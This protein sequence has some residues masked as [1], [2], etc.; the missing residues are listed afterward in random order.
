MIHALYRSSDGQLH[1]DLKPDDFKAAL[2][3]ERSL[4]WVDLQGEPPEA[5]EPILRDVFGFH[6]LAVDDALRESHVP[7]LDDWGEYLYLVLHAVILSEQGSDPVATL[8]LDIFFGKNYVV[9]YHE[10]PIETLDRVWNLSQRGDRHLTH[11]ADHLLYRLVDELVAGYMPLADSMDEIIDDLEDRILAEPTSS[12]LE[13]ILAL[14]RGLH[15]LRRI[16][17]PQREVLNKLARD[18]YTVIDAEDRPFFRDVYDHL[19]RLYDIN[20]SM[21]DLVSDALSTYLSVVNN[22]MNDI[23]KTLTVITT[24][25]M[26]ISFIASFFGM[27]FFQPVAKPLMPWTSLLWFALTL[28]AVILTPLAMFL[29]IRRKGWM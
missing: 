25:F 19:V 4:L 2:Q 26:P 18:S 15:H 11:G 24:L 23:M 3:D 1:L 6:P 14:K 10:H 29:W 12:N 5:S 8:E 17:A 13:R 21:R 16:I 27:N 22:R 20:E 9:T 7:K 28:A